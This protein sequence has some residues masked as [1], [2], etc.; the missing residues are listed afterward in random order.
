[1][2][3]KLKMKTGQKLK[4]KLSH[5]SKKWKT[6]LTIDCSLMEESH[7]NKKQSTLFPEQ[8]KPHKKDSPKGCLFHFN[9][10]RLTLDIQ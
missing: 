3:G 2:T 7:K 4:K 1:M 10:R 5:Y 8:S 9:I 6:I